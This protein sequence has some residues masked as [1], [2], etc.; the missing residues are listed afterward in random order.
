MNMVTWLVKEIEMGIEEEVLTAN[1][2]TYETYE[3]ALAAMNQKVQN[4]ILF[5]EE[6]SLGEIE[7]EEQGDTGAR[8]STAIGQV[9]LFKVES[10]S[11]SVVA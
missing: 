6:Y 2:E 11:S 7:V 5:N 1:A 9:W 4:R 8:L 3:L 10:V